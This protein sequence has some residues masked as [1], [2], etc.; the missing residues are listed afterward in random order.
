MHT[1]LIIFMLYF[2]LFFF[3]LRYQHDNHDPKNGN[4]YF[5]RMIPMRVV[6]VQVDTII[7]PWG[8]LVLDN[9]LF[10]LIEYVKILRHIRWGEVW[11]LEWKLIIFIFKPFWPRES[12]FRHE[13]CFGGGHH[14]WFKKEIKIFKNLKIYFFLIFKFYFDSDHQSN[15][16]DHSGFIFQS[17]IILILYS[18]FDFIF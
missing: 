18:L 4:L 13:K 11:T 2:I 12:L 3:L 6:S 15:M 10:I 7:L 5:A 9:W 16:S 14:F 8:L 17:I 1:Q